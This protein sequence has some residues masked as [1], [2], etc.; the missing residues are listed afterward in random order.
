MI[1]I[2][3]TIYVGVDTSKKQSNLH[4]AEI[5]PLGDSYNEKKKLHNVTKK[6]TNIAEYENIPLPGFTLLKTDKK[7][8]WSSSDPSWLVIDPRGFLVR[9][10]SKNLENILHVTGITEGLIQQKCVWA[11]ENSQTKMTLVPVSSVKYLEAIANTDL[12]ENKVDISE[13]GIGDTVLLQNGLTGKYMGVVSLYSTLQGIRYNSEEHK[14]QS[15]PRR[16]VVELKAGHYYYQTDL[17]ILKIIK[18]ADISMTKNDAVKSMND[19]ILAGGCYFTSSS[20]TSA[21][22][23]YTSSYGMVNHTSDVFIP[24]VGM[25]LSEISSTEAEHL[26]NRGQLECDFGLLVLEDISGNRYLIDHPQSIYFNSQNLLKPSVSS[27]LVS[28]ISSNTSGKFDSIVLKSK[29]NSYF[30]F[31]TTTQVYYNFADFKKFYKIV[32]HV[33]NNTYI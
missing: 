24:R 19:S 25:T 17:K 3:K 12:I 26:Y 8:S 22:V 29:R 31:N 9:I 23:Q 21:P 14:I 7:S 5:V 33:K 15:M 1:N 18:K 6:Y 28:E 20:S 13:V 32:K 30:L 2:T 27:F 4:E 16:Q 10:T 11:R